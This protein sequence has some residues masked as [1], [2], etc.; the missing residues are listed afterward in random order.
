[1]TKFQFRITSTK[2]IDRF[3]KFNTTPMAIGS[4]KDNTIR[5][6]KILPHHCVVYINS[7]KVMVNTVDKEA[8]C[9]INE[10]PITSGPVVLDIGDKLSFKGCDNLFILEELKDLTPAKKSDASKQKLEEKKIDTEIVQKV[11]ISSGKTV[12]SVRSINPIEKSVDKVGISGDNIVESVLSINQSEKS[13]ESD[14]TKMAKK[15][16]TQKTNTK[17]DNTDKR[18]DI[19]CRLPASDSFNDQK[20]IVESISQET[21]KASVQS[22]PKETKKDVVQSIPQETVKT[23]QPN[24]KKDIVQSVPQEAKKNIVQAI[25]QETVKTQTNSTLARQFSVSLMDDDTVEVIN[26]QPSI[27]ES[28]KKRKRSDK[29]DNELERS[30]FKLKKPDNVVISKQRANEQKRGEDEETVSYDVLPSITH[31]HQYSMDIIE[32]SEDLYSEDTSIPQNE[33]MTASSN[34]DGDKK[35]KIESDESIMQNKSPRTEIIIRDSS[36]S[37]SSDTT[38]SSPNTKTK[39]KSTKVTNSS[40]K[41]RTTKKTKSL[42][43]GKKLQHCS[44]SESSSTTE[45]SVTEEIILFKDVIPQQKDGYWKLGDNAPKGHSSP[46]VNVRQIRDQMHASPRK[47]KISRPDRYGNYC[48]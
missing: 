35:T 17:K 47:R 7:G 33:Q 41:K 26:D 19:E 30:P 24:T 45:S 29:S 5:V 37:T 27:A 10:K 40:S 38:K 9:F 4:S 34:Y 39:T 43:M 2:G 1:M 18:N 22:T 36:S 46:R 21:K 11:E 42:N 48:G 6:K 16:R 3:K 28:P 8:V 14:K 25:S 12:E 32:L 31:G 13:T 15:K 20:D 23:A 44:D